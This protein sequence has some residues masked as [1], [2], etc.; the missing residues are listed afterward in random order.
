MHKSIKT[1][2][3]KEFRM[4]KDTDS[5][6]PRNWDNLCTL[7]L[8]G[9]YKLMGDTHQM[10]KYMSIEEIL[11]KM[12]AVTIQPIYAYIHGGISISLTPFNCKW[13]SGILGFA[14]ITKEAIRENYGIKRVTKKYVEKAQEQIAGEVETLNQWINDDVYGFDITDS[15]GVL[16]EG[17]YGFYG[18]NPLTNGMMDHIM[19]DDVRKLISSEYSTS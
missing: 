3:D 14:L 4:Y 7:I 6:S 13:D 19:D 1:S 2:N 11:K 15:E 17:C 10:N 8:F 16:N 9:R 12:D 18:D 5:E